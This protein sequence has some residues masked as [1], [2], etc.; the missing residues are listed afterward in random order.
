MKN[1]AHHIISVALLTAFAL[2]MVVFT[3]CEPPDSGDPTPTAVPTAAP[4]SEP[5]ETPSPTTEPTPTPDFQAGDVWIITGDDYILQSAQF[6][7]E[8]HVNSGDQKVA[9]Y[10]ITINF[11][12]TILSVNTSIGSS[13][14]TAGP[15]GFVA[16]VNTTTP[17]VIVIS[18][19][20]TGGKGPGTDLNM[21]TVNWTAIAAGTSTLSVTV[22]DLT[23]ETTAEI[24][25]P[26]GYDGSVTVL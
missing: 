6:T 18:G 24:G 3:A 26:T 16:A 11:D 14:V 4:T 1:Q 2:L 5:T 17:G 19:F 15:D 22:D 21:F 20:D 25:T 8:V 10:G 13:G 9:A 23:D 12:Q 7:T